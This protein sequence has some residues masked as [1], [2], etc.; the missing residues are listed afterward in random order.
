[1]KKLALI[2]VAVTLLAS[3]L[4]GC[5]LVED[6]TI[7]MVWYPNESGMDV[8]DARDEIGKIVA[9]ATGKTVEHKLTT[10]YVI[11]IEAIV[12]GQADLAFMGAVG[13]IM[14]NT[15][16]AKVLPL[17][18]NSGRSGTLSDAVYYSWMIVKEGN[19]GQYKTGDTFSLD[20]IAGKRFSFVSTASTSGFVVP[21]AAIV[22]HFSAKS[23]W[24]NIK[25][26]DVTEGGQGKLFSAVL[27]GGSH[28]GSTFNVLSD[29]ADIAATC[30]VCIAND[31]ELV[32]GTHNQA[33]AVYRVRDTAPAPFNTMP[34]ARFVLISS[35][36]VLNAPFVVNTGTVNAKDLAALRTLFT[37]EEV[38]KNERIFIPSGS[39][40]KGFYRQGQRFLVVDDAWFNPIRAL[41]GK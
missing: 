18:V 25:Q 32:S 19:E 24:Q 38:T 16:N 41:G 17:V 30:D 13:Y 28:Q 35:I 2:L 5:G 20:N 1:M 29:R 40:F 21:A 22:N 23:P 12:S 26:E 7:T 37:S 14:A 4:T 31:I 36:P 3:L 11:A 10:D 33:G 6:K 9:Q 15:R 39:A 8:K 34:G 27:Y